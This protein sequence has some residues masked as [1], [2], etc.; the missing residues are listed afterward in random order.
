[1]MELSCIHLPQLVKRIIDYVIKRIYRDRYN[2]VLQ[3]AFRGVEMHKKYK[4]HHSNEF[5]RGN[6]GAGGHLVSVAMVF[7]P[8]QKCLPQTAEV[9]TASLVFKFG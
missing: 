9:S 8:S 5:T 3:Q 4:N 6:T 1:M 2:C 7:P